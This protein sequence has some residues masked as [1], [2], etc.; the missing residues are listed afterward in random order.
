MKIETVLDQYA[1][2]AK[3]RAVGLTQTVA[4]IPVRR[5]LGHIHA[6]KLTPTDVSI[7]VEARRRGHYTRANSNKGAADATIR[8]ELGALSAALNWAH[9][10][11]ILSER[12]PTIDLPPAS[13]PREVILSVEDANRLWD[14]AAERAREGS[15]VGLFVCIALDTWAR[16][17]AIETLTWDRVDLSRSQIDYRDPAKPETAK[18]RVPVP[19]SG[20]LAALLSWVRHTRPSEPGSEFVVGPITQY[21]WKKLRESAGVSGDVTRHDLRRTGISAAVGRGVD[22]LKVATMAG[23]D[24]DTIL[25]HYARFAPD[26][27]KGVVA[28]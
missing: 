28:A 18:R 16:S 7:Y 13:P 22:L 1:V 26:Y 3:V 19:V 27:L 9:D 8:R 10:K 25:K 15:R 12:P 21:A 20:R 11:R 14:Y 24:Y 4:L 17:A 2:G 23:D 6:E 5:G